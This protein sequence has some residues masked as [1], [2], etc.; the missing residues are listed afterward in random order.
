[1]KINRIKKEKD[2]VILSTNA[3]KNTNLSWAA[4]GLH[5]FIMQL[6]DDWDLNV[7]GL[8]GFS[9]VGRDGTAAIIKELINAGYIDR[10]KIK[11]EKNQFLGYEYN[12][13]EMPQP[14]NAI[15]ENGKAVNGIPVNGLAENG[16]AVTMKYEDNTIVLSN[17]ELTNE[18]K[19]DLKKSQLSPT[20]K[21]TAKKEKQPEPIEE[22]TYEQEQILE[23]AKE[24]NT[25]PTKTEIM[26]AAKPFLVN[27]GVFYELR[28]FGVSRQSR[29]KA[30]R[31][32]Y[33]AWKNMIEACITAS[34][35]HEPKELIQLISHAKNNSYS[36]PFFNGYKDFLT[37]QNGKQNEN[38]SSNN[39]GYQSTSE[40][41]ENALRQNQERILAEYNE[42]RY[43][44]G[45]GEF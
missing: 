45:G 24:A 10:V 15:P 9:S 26:N 13:Y 6:P 30:K 17:K 36:S 8:K 40:K 33:A 32:S 31:M 3:L 18:S 27:E 38:H 25:Q 29:A 22:L 20:K 11:N 39:N 42:Q 41:F 5:S 23:A 4:K 2:F 34:Q 16:K 43:G 7:E 44:G 28:I 21:T 37:K 1:M 19:S 12:I 14:Q 35:A